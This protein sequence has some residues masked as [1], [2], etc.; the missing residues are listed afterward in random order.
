MF[1]YL[2][3]MF[4]RH[5]KN[6]LLEYDSVSNYRTQKI[7]LFSSKLSEKNNGHLIC[8]FFKDKFIYVF[9]LL[10]DFSLVFLALYYFMFNIFAG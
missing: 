10:L 5:K 3:R 7:E 1:S 8:P 9:F 2:F 4:F 6:K